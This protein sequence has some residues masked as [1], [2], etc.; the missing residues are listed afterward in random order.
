MLGHSSEF[1]LIQELGGAM[2]S[3]LDD[4]KKQKK[5]E[6]KKAKEAAKLA[7]KQS[8]D[9]PKRQK[10][11]RFVSGLELY[12]YFLSNL[13]SRGELL[14]DKNLKD[15]EIQTGFNRIRTTTCTKVYY[16]V[17][18]L[19]RDI[20]LALFTEIRDA[21][22]REMVLVNFNINMSPHRINW[23]SWEM[24]EKRRI[25]TRN[26]QNETE[27]DRELL[28]SSQNL[29]LS[30]REQW[31]YDS[32]MYITRCDIEKISM[33]LMDLIIEISTRDNSE[34]SITQ[35]RDACTALEQY[36]A[37]A[38]I[39]LKRMQN[40][41]LDFLEYSSPILDKPDAVSRQWVPDRMLTDEVI[42]WMTTFEPGKLS[43]RGCILGMD[44]Y[45]GKLV[46]QNF[47]KTQ[48]EA[49]NFLVT[50]ETG[51]GKS[52]MCKCLVRELMAAGLNNIILDRDGE[53]KPLT[54]AF[55]G[56]IIDLDRSSGRYFDSMQIGDLTGIPE[57]DNSLFTESVLTTTAIFNVLIDSQ[58]G[59]SFNEKKIFNDAYNML[60]KAH[61]I[62]KSKPETW[63]NSNR[64]TFKLL[65]DQILI[66]GRHSAYQ[67]AYGAE[68][69]AFCSK[70]SMFFDP[71]GL[72]S[73]LF[74]ERI[75]INDI[76]KSGNRNTPMLLDI[77]MYID[78]DTDKTKD[79]IVET[80]VK[81]MTASYLIILLTNYYKS[82]N[83]YTVHFIEEF[84][85]YVEHK[86]IQALV[87][88]MITGNRKRNADTLLITNSPM[89]LLRGSTDTSYALVENINNFI[90]GGLKRE[91]V[92]ALCQTFGLSEC[93]DMLME[94]SAKSSTTF[95][96]CFLVKQDRGEVA[97]VVQ[98]IPEEH[99][100]SSMFSTEGSK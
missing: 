32:W 96:H 72:R 76:V 4:K 34:L 25:W 62:V 12:S 5:L 33:C 67:K 88:N 68:L 20:P 57:I 58:N 56:T 42:A 82:K 24:K 30:E 95:K 14:P 29:Q 46:Y 80:L 22:E 31:L 45:T 85:R 79:G 81:Q 39:E 94:M 49:K 91:T 63:V 78:N 98:Q 1:Y 19:P 83:Q 17:G 100:A 48:G 66:L 15:D 3:L 74:R 51:G 13:I 10:K 27:G 52:T 16:T 71:G 75:S 89:S 92:K 69:S 21:V 2:P 37:S 61:G 47:R 38:G 7:K 77:C 44:I 70:L 60:L 90:I 84:Q 87:L 23:N 11:K 64:L 53:Y 73:H 59:M 65:Y 86:E 9:T 54:R 97:V 41:I 36:A 55:G 99:L 18:V 6:K 26:L 35:L 43:D 40:Y 93:E 8:K 50:A 28:K